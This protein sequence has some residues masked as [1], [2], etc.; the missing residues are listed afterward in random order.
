VADLI[1][2]D[3]A[4]ARFED[5]YLTGARFRDVDLADARFQLVNLSGVTIRGAALMD[6]T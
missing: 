5:V 3:L 2:Q 4:G 6:M 1:K